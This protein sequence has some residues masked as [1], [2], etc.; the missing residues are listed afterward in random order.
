MQPGGEPPK[1]KV[2]RGPDGKLKVGDDQ[3]PPCETVEP[4]NGR[5][6]PERSAPSTARN[7]PPLGAGADAVPSGRAR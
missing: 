1:L 7:V 4:P 5:P 2:R 3:E 6:Q